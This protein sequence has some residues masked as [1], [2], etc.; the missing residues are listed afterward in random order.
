[1]R[2]GAG[3]IPELRIVKYG[4][5]GTTII[6]EETLTY[7]EMMQRFDVIGNGETVYKFQGVTF[8]PE[9]I[10]DENETGKGGYK[11]ANAV[12]GTRISDLCSLVGGMGT[13]TEVVLVASDG[14]ETRL[15][16][17]SIYPDP[18]VYA[19]QGDA[20]LAWYADGKYVPDYRDGMRLYFT[21]EDTVYSQMDMRLTMPEPY[22]HYYYADV[23]Y[24]SCAG[25]SAKY[26]TEI[27]V[28]SVPQG[29]WILELDGT[30]IGGIAC[31]I[32]KTYFESAL[33]CQFGA[34][35][36]ASYTDSE[37]RK[38]EGMPIWFLVGFVDDADQHSDNAFNNELA[39]A[40]YQVVI[41]ARDGKL[42]T[43]NS[44]DIIRNN[45]HIIANTLNGFPIPETDDNWPLRLV[46]PAVSGSL[47]I[48]QIV[49]H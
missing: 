48:G 18:S 25:L 38:W 46:G 49:K 15:P 21:P 31:D 43:L 40:G 36:K 12:K 4:E 3:T 7:L 2:A 33:A 13:G 22:W 20:I 24:P 19:R 1:L 8:D 42:V 44:Q 26:I 5:D 11:I 47:S 10:W 28:Y 39:N 29:D 27:R 34:N 17:S 6:A 45:N 23:M 32:S 41:T 14:Y 30:E 16:Y 35:H 9:D 37:G